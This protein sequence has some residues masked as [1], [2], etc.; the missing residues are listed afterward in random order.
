MLA[1]NV[2][3]AQL[4]NGET[5]PNW[6][7]TDLNGNPHT[8]YNY[9][10]NDKIVFL[11][12]MATWC[13]P[14]WN[15][16][17]THAFR[18]LYEAHGP[19]G[20]DNVMTFMIEAD[21]DTNT[22]CLYD[23]PNCVGGT[24]GNWVT[25]TP[26]PIIDNDS[27]NGAYNINYYPT[28]YAVC[29]DKKIY[30]LDQLGAN[31]LW[32]VAQWCS[33]PDLT[34]DAVTH[35]NCYGNSNG[36]ITASANGGMPPFTYAWSNGANTLSIANLPAGSYTLTV[37]GS[38]GGTKTLGPIAV[39]QP[40]APLSVGIT[41]IQPQG[42]AGMG[43]SIEI[44]VTGGTPAY[45]YLWSNGSTAPM[46]TGLTAGTYAVSITDANACTTAQGNMYVAPP[47]YP[48]ASAA[49]PGVLT[50][51]APSLTLNGSG[52]STGQQFSYL[53]TTADG[54]I[55]SGANTLNN[56]IVNEAGTYQLMVLKNSNNCTA[57]ASTVVTANQTEPI[58]SAG[59]PGNLTCL[60]SQTTLIGI[61]PSGQGYSI[62]WTTIGG[63]IVS[64]ATTLSPVVNAAGSYT[65]TLTNT[66]NGC[67]GTSTT[68]VTSN[69]STPNATANGGQITCTNSTV[70]L[71]GNSTTPGVTYAWTGPNNFTSSAQNPVV[72]VQGTYFLTVTKTSN[73]CT[74]T[75][76]AVVAQNTTAP[77]AA[78]QGGTLNCLVSSVMLGGSS[79]TP[80]VTYGWT[81]PNSYT[82]SQQNPTVGTPGNYLVT[83]T[84]PNGCT[85]A[86]TG[87]VSQN[88][89]TPNANAGPSG[90]LNCH[91]D[92][93]VLNGTASSTGSQYGYGWTTANGHIVSGATTLTPTV[94]EAGNYSLMVTNATNG[95]TGT[96]STPVAQRQP[97]TASIASQTNVPCHGDPSGSAT[98]AGGGGNGSFTY[99]WSTGA[100]TAAVANLAAG[101]Y[102][103]VVTDG[104][105]C[106]A[107]KTLTI[108]EPS[109]LS[110][111]TTSTAQTAHGTN[112][113][114]ASA[115]PQGGAGGYIYQ[116]SNSGTTQTITGLAPGNYT[117]VVTDGNGCTETQTVTVNAFGC[118]ISASTF[119][120][121]ASCHGSSDGSAGITLANA[122]MPQVFLWSNGAQT[123][124]VSGL[125]PGSYT[126]SA[127]DGNG[128]QVVASLEIDEP[129]QL[130]ANATT[131]GLTA[132]GANDGTATASPTGGTGPFT[133]AWS[134]PTGASGA[135]AQ[136][137]TGLASANYTVSVTDSNGCVAVQTVPVAPFG[138][139]TL[140]NIASSNISCFGEADGQ[141]TVTLTGGLTPYTYHWSND[142]ATATISG[143]EAGTYTV[144]VTDAVNCPAIVEV[145]ILE[146]ALLEAG[147][148][149]VSDTDCGA[150]NG[151]AT[152]S[153]TGG[154]PGPGYYFVWSNGQS[155]PS[156]IN[157]DAGSYSVFV[158]DL[159]N[160]QVVVEVEISIND[161]VPPTV[162]TQ[163]LTL[164]LNADGL[165]NVT[166]SQVNNGSTDNCE[167]T[168]M[169]IDLGGF[170]C[171]DLGSHEVTLT[172]VD[173]AGNTSSGTA[174]VEVVD[175]TPPIISVQNQVVS[176]DENG[177]AT[178]TPQVLDN[179][180]TDNC[181]IAERT[182]D[183]ASFTCA[184]IGPNAVVLTVMDASGNMAAGTA[185]VTIQDNIAPA[186]TCPADMTLPY[187]QPV[188]AFEIETSDNC[189]Q[190]LS[191]VQTSGLPSG[192]TFPTGMTVQTFEVNDGQ[193]NHNT[194]SFSIEVPAAMQVD[195]TA[196]D[197][198]CF[199]GMDGSIASNVSGGGSQGYAY[200]W[201]TGATT[202][203]IENLGG[204]N[205]SLSVTDNAGCESVQTVGLS[206]PMGIAIMPVQVTPE[207]TGQQNGAIDV[208][209]AGGVQPYSFEW[210]DANGMV[211]S[212]QEDVSGI[213]AGN[214]TLVVT[215]ANGCT[216]LHVFT[217]QSVSGT[218][219]R[220]LER[221]IGLFPNPTTGFV[222][223]AFEEME[224]LEANI[225]VFDMTGKKAFSFAHADVSSGLFLLDVSTLMDGVYMVRIVVEDGV[226]AKRL[227]VQR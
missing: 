89:T 186:I 119:F 28:L 227:V 215:D 91:A 225:S 57:F 154:T 64:G 114:T 93:V 142:E 94:D 2:L 152:V 166:A 138:C 141:A 165:A 162:F 24:W 79:T 218:V 170:T 8:L 33:A 111:S 161:A 188:A 199:G 206:E 127:T 106:G 47:T 97:V 140:A 9:L 74:A 99:A 63:N 116:W 83:V 159:N 149:G 195:L 169:A 196:N 221:S 200:I 126:V 109:E 69:I 16:H 197:I 157:L 70:Q 43:G 115:N 37:T 71:S 6:T 117:V 76:N 220:R 132:A 42:C 68:N 55:F 32:A 14:C 38:L 19:P 217:V 34:L 203:S 21:G 173:E 17:N 96:A 107:T 121:D 102:T 77:Q 23:Q 56:C 113:G 59:P 129:G 31:D 66:A 5:A 146:P 15:Y 123:Q 191:P 50:C 148:S 183:K 67:T 11:D 208:S 168:S 147:L 103:V 108:T 184:D 54:H 139:S 12:F 4:P 194:C 7:M 30:E 182:I 224:A 100:S 49:T 27:Q 84:A 36:A 62:L 222:T 175:N 130:T 45:S 90:V 226:V 143:L 213:A 125:A 189:A 151:T 187:C 82:S 120:E 163:N 98:A 144:S 18:T 112:D 104:E 92:E 172:V 193:G 78:A 110:V 219:Q 179:G 185:I 212:T 180:S 153:A 22:P 35:I 87:I 81:G 214:Y 26:Y 60:M 58:I 205:Y 44:S 105:N 53:W 51:T 133:F 88:T 210:T 145:A 209:V 95:C 177:M 73:G 52:S 174:T 122:D 160:C 85:Q 48:V 216:S 158:G 131:T 13:S 20:T 198:S 72:S 137:I 124:T 171:N 134:N 65:I 204:G 118:A 181:G 61:G 46:A 223:I 190:A 178:I 156:A 167:I 40:A 10:D 136:T 25:G 3:L 101:N 201:N 176:L 128:C 1:A 211:V 202:P 39:N 80:G 41:N 135:T 86:A 29:P 150:A 207:T 164:P 192:A 75:A 155:G